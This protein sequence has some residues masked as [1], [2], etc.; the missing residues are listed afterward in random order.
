MPSYYS[1]EKPVPTALNEYFGILFDNYFYQHDK[2]I[3]IKQPQIAASTTKIVYPTKW[4]KITGTFKAEQEATHL[5]L[6]QFLKEGEN[7][8]IAKGYFFIDDV[9]VEP[10]ESTAVDFEPSRYYN[11]KGS[12]ASVIM[13]NIY[14]ET[15]KYELLPESF[16]ELDKLVN[17]M[18]KNP[19]LSIQIQG[20]TDSEGSEGYNLQLS[21]HRAKN[22]QGLF[23]FTR[24]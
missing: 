6:G 1:K 18:N 17:I 20:H 5:Y 12:V 19:T 14:F 3:L 22:G 21:D 9:F 8:P 4:Q 23:S 15:D 13:E 24:H 2:R 11:I 10:F 7:P 16:E